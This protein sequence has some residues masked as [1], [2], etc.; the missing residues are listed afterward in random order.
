MTKGR[1]R[2]FKNPIVLREML[3]LRLQGWPLRLLAEKYEVDHSS[4]RR[5]CL[6]NGL[7][8]EINILP[9]PIISFRRVIVDY[10]GERINRGRTYKEYLAMP[11]VKRL[12]IVRFNH[13]DQEGPRNNG[14]YEEGVRR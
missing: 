11:H 12:T 10:N 9:E 7:P 1:P 5:A 13:A 3:T 2:A 6:R 8:A 14:Q 4:I